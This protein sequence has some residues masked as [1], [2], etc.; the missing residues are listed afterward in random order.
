MLS[1]FTGH[2]FTILQSLTFFSCF[3]HRMPSTNSSLLKMS[4]VTRKAKFYLKCIWSIR[5]L[6]TSRRNSSLSSFPTCMCYL[7]FSA[8]KCKFH[9]LIDWLIDDRSID[10]LIVQCIDWPIDWLIDLHFSIYLLQRRQCPFVCLSTPHRIIHPD[11]EEIWEILKTQF[12]EVRFQIIFFI[13]SNIRATPVGTDEADEQM[14]Q[15]MIERR[16]KKHWE[17]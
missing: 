8:Q 9:L 7:V 4:W 10:W 5:S 16:E 13:L 1:D 14:W 17:R 3:S 6:I 2:P 12:Y 11:D 15:R